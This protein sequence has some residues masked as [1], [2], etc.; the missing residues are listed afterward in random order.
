MDHEWGVIDCHAHVGRF[1][2]YDLS[3]RTLMAE[4][5]RAGI[6]LALVS[7]ID[8]AAVAGKTRDLAER[9]VNVATR[10]VIDRY[11]DRLRGLL[12]GR[13]GSGSADQLREFVA[14]RVE[15]GASKS[16]RWTDRSFVGIKLH[17][18]MNHFEADAPSVDPYLDLA[19]EAGFAVVFHC[20]GAIERASVN[21]ILRLAR[22]HP[23]VP[24][25]LYH[26]GFGGPHRPVIESVAETLEA[27]EADVYL[28]TAQLPAEWALRAV[29]RAGARRVLF[30]TDATYYGAGHYQRYD[31]LRTALHDALAP[32]DLQRVLAGNALRIFRL[33][34]SH[35]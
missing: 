18:E 22:R 29:E 27:G 11:P 33:A 25:V 19:R 30:G 21:R 9:P 6:A 23:D 10:A 28:E 16:G 26:T 8:G 15:A 35:D 31:E 5:D 24:V 2:G 1:R 13:P 4:V 17:P 7:N 14:A 34:G 3:L 32:D 12:W 20:D